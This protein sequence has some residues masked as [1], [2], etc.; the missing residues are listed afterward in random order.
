MSVNQYPSLK[1]ILAQHVQKAD[2]ERYLFASRFV[3]RPPSFPAI[4]LL[5]RLG[6]SSEAASWLSGLAAFAAYACLLWPGAPLLWPGVAL[7]ML[8]NFSDCLDGGIARAMRTRNPY[9]RFLDSIMGWADMIFWTVIGV[10]VWR[11]PELR[12]AGDALGLPPLVWAAA[13]VLCSFFVCYYSS[14]EVMFDQVLRPYWEPSSG[15]NGTVPSSSP[16]RGKT[17]AAFWGRVVVSNLRVRET[18]YLLLAAA[19]LTGT[20]DLLLAFFLAFS[21]LFTAVL[22][23]TYCRRGKAVFNSGAGREPL[24]K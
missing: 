19:C 11:L 9:G 23:V 20:A 2:Y 17:G 16:L 13:G 1:E 12:A 3:F 8:F 4:W 5:V 7:L 6:V 14:L 22:L 18:H 15:G 10:T 24:P 21:G